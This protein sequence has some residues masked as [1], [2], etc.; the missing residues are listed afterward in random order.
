M[1]DKKDPLILGPQFDELP[2]IPPQDSY[3]DVQV[4][5]GH[6]KLPTDP[7]P[8]ELL[9]LEHFLEPVKAP[10]YVVDGLF[11]SSSVVGVVAAPEAGKSLLM[12]EIAVCVALGQPFHG[13]KVKRGLVVY[14]VG[15]GKH[16]LFAR[17]QALGTRYNFSADVCPL[18]VAKSPTSLIDGV[19]L[20]RVEEA[21]RRKVE[22][23]KMPLTL[24]IV[25]TLARF[26]AP[27]DESK[28]MDMG[29]YLTA[30]DTLRGEAAAVTLHHPGH[31]DGTRGRGSSSWK[32]GLDT[33]YSLANVAGTVTVTCQKMK[34]GRKPDP[35]SFR[36]EP[37]PTKMAREDGTPL[38][39]VLLHSTDYQPVRR[40]LTGKAQKKL[41]AALEAAD[42]GQTVWTEAE[43]RK[44][45]RDAGLHKNTARDAVLGLRQYDYLEMTVCG[46]RLK[47][48]PN[49]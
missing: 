5:N 48:G 40:P 44:I 45:G 4:A 33:E 13:R 15:E 2:E 11:E 37:A 27:G 32:A 7:K 43:L 9:H 26:I 46:S 23:F 28:A 31:G 3:A 29:S 42:Q 35:F 16:G 8:Y 39:S 36:I 38:T 30:I 12:Q 17:F 22:L 19:E 6:D 47:T 21:I 20:L 49:S 34:D 10:E 18:V 1:I 41:L 25:D 14:L 24:L